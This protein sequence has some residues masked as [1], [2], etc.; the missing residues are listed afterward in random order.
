MMT[1]MRLLLV[2]LIIKPVNNTNLKLKKFTST[3][4]NRK[5]LNKEFINSK[6]LLLKLKQHKIQYPYIVLKQAILE[7]GWFKSNVLKTHNNLFGFR[8]SKGYIKFKTV[9]ESIIYYKNW[10][11]KR[12]KGGDYYEFLVNIKYAEDTM[13]IYKLKNIGI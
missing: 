3:T 5:L 1:L 8:T 4:I 12:Y 13:Y 2:I 9:D 7:T 10:Q 6:L 11:A